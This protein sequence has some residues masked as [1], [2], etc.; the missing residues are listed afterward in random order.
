MIPHKGFS[1]SL[2]NCEEGR[3]NV[4]V[5]KGESLNERSLHQSPYSTKTC[6]IIQETTNSL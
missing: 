2:N 3:I 5:K 6:S 4:D 1:Y